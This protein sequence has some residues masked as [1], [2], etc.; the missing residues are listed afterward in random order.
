METSWTSLCSATLCCCCL[1][2]KAALALALFLKCPTRHL[3]AAMFRDGVLFKSCIYSLLQSVPCTLNSLDIFSGWIMRQLIRAQHHIGSIVM[4]NNNSLSAITSPSSSVM[5]APVWLASLTLVSS[6]N[7][8]VTLHLVRGSYVY[9]E[10][11]T[12]QLLIFNRITSFSVLYLLVM[13]CIKV[14]HQVRL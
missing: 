4:D 3:T 6:T 2:V 13:V 14:L 1:S 9:S 5:F 10:L 7:G 8:H 11:T 12:V